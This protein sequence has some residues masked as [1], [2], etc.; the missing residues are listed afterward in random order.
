MTGMA[1]EEWPHRIG[2]GHR[3]GSWLHVMGV[4]R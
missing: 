2:Y 1:R 4:E 3:V